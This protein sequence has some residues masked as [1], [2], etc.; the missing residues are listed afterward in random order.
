[1]FARVTKDHI[2]RV[3]DIAMPPDEDDSVTP[4]RLQIIMA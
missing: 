3:A 1:M 4:R 2:V